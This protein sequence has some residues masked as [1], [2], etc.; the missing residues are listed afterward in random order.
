M[1]FSWNSTIGKLIVGGCGTQIGLLFGCGS[2]AA[3]LLLCFVCTLSN[4]VGIGL[5]QEMA[6]RPPPAP[7]EAA[8]PGG[9]VELLREEMEVL[10]REVEFLRANGSA[11]P[12]TLTSSSKPI[13]IANQGG[14]N[15]R[16]GPGVDYNKLGFLPMG[17]H[18]E[19]VGRNSDSTWWLVSTPGGF[20]WAS[21]RA[22]TAV[23]V[24][25][26]IPIVTIPALLVQ[27][28][29]GPS[30][31]AFPTTLPSTGQPTPEA[32]VPSGTPTP[33]ANEARRFVEDTLGYKEIGNYLLKPPVSASFS[34]QGDQ[35]AITEGIKLYTIAADGS[36]SYVW[37][38]NDET[39]NL[40]GDTVWSPD[41]EYIAFVA[42]ANPSCNTCR[43][44]GLF[45]LS[46]KSVTF[47]KPP[48]GL[49][50]HTPRWT[51][52]GRQLLVNAHVGEP[53]DGV[54]YVYDISS[55]QSQVASGR[56]VLSSSHEGQKWFPWQPGKTWQAGVS[57]RPDSYNSN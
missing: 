45:R 46:D 20:A 56:Y 34:P 36:S 21:D 40:V 35:I 8:S 3:V 15:L 31:S 12:E 52:D 14:V 41:G 13:V 47:L 19:I 5:A 22:V 9:E 17:G 51:E 57:E 38:E 2:L 23:N 6:R 10:F 16:S 30:S 26:S 29:S 44:V 7:V 49:G 43:K 53:A 33:V 24:N 39:L 27:P 4:V 28:G 11:M 42:D 48:S 55:G 54:T 25:D 37:L 1:N 50:I 32:M 18:L